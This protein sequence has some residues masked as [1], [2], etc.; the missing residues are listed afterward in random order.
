M[1]LDI[2]EIPICEIS[3]TCDNL[4]CDMFG[5]RPTT[6][7]VVEAFII[8]LKCWIQLGTTELIEV[9]LCFYV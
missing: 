4:L 2:L 7:I 9:L 3:M 8:N 1:W 5:C 6:F